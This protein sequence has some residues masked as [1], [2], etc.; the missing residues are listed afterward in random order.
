MVDINYQDNT[1]GRALFGWAGGKF[2]LKKVIVPI[3]NSIHHATYIEPFCGALNILL[4]KDKVKGVKAYNE[5]ANDVYG[6]IINFYEVIKTDRE[7]FIDELSTS[8]KVRD[9]YNPLYEEKYEAYINKSPITRACVFYIRQKMAFGGV[10]TK[11]GSSL[12][13]G[14]IKLS[15]DKIISDIKKAHIR[16]SNV[17]FSSMD[18]FDFISRYSFADTLYY[19]D[20]P[21][22]GTYCYYNKENKKPFTIED[23]T[24]R[25]HD[26]LK[27]KGRIL[28]SL[29]NLPEIVD[30]YK[31][32]DYN[33]YELT[34]I[35]T[36]AKNYDDGNVRR[37]EILISNFEI[38]SLQKS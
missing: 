13:N 31:S 4:A 16:I 22:P 21:Y 30:F 12:C 8:F 10:L 38:G 36:M 1:L 15:S 6:E 9:F 20:P 26:V 5:F 11:T 17:N 18:A 24:C 14:F 25:L 37:K 32:R 19:L 27:N 23:A 33:I 7:S 3:L 34:T 29:N 35:R 28:I 2:Y